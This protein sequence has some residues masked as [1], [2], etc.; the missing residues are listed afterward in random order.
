MEAVMVRP[1]SGVTS[2]DVLAGPAGPDFSTYY[3]KELSSLVWFAMSLGAD[4]HKAADIAQ[5]AFM[6][7]FPVWESI[8]CPNAWLRRVAG[9]IY[10]RQLTSHESLVEGVP[11]QAGPMSITSTAEFRDEARAVLEALADLPPKQRQVM[12]WYVDG[13]SPAEIVQELAADP[14]AVRQNLAKARR[15]LKKS[16][17]I[18]GRG[19]DEHEGRARLQVE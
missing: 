2:R 8:R 15:N 3:A 12:A 17:G 9:R 6:E 7:A 19:P 10:F 11:E 1:D 14:A 4:A 16:L 18:V 5:S 13:F